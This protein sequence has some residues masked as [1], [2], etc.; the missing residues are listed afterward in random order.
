MGANGWAMSARSPP[1]KNKHDKEK[2][3]STVLAT[4]YYFY[5]VTDTKTGKEQYFE[6]MED[7]ASATGMHRSTAHYKL[8]GKV[9]SG[10]SAKYSHLK[11]DRVKIPCAQ[12]VEQTLPLPSPPVQHEPESK[13]ADAA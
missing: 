13:N 10:R 3:A 12:V 9:K 11:V 8:S 1:E 5:K 4:K 6:R 2:M 7:L